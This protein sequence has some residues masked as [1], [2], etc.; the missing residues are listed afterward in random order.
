[1]EVLVERS[2]RPFDDRSVGVGAKY[3]AVSRETSHP[4][5]GELGRR[6][7]SALIVLK[8]VATNLPWGPPDTQAT[9]PVGPRA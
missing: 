4:E 7:D 2:L 9:E 1:M 8:L 3:G 6:T 5:A